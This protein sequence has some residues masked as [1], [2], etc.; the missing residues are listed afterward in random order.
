MAKMAV[1]FHVRLQRFWGSAGEREARA[2]LV[3]DAK[4]L[5][6]FC[7]SRTSYVACPCVKTTLFVTAE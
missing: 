3:Q 4:R 6:Y 1:K 5:A 7:V 2:M